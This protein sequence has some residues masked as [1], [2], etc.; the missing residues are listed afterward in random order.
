M[1][2]LKISCNMH[3]YGS[4]QFEVCIQSLTSNVSG[5]MQRLDCLEKATK[6]LLR[7][8][9]DFLLYASETHKTKPTAVFWE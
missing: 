6:F 9:P 2:T 3:A 5:F 7:S 8:F 4:L 1:H